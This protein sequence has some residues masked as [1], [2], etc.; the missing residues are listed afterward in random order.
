M[1]GHDFWNDL[2]YMWSALP[3]LQNSLPWMWNLFNI[4]MQRL[5][6]SKNVYSEKLS[7]RNLKWSNAWI[8]FALSLAL[9]LQN[10]GSPVQHGAGIKFM[11]AHAFLGQLRFWNSEWIQFKWLDETGSK[12]WFQ[13]TCEKVKSNF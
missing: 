13:I 11:S 6:F 9:W 7:F 8:S 2:P 12:F 3:Y 10:H 4:L 5:P 1:R